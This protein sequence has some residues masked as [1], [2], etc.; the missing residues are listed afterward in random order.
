MIATARNG[1]HGT[2]G[3]GKTVTYVPVNQTEAATTIL[4]AASIGNKHKVLGA[5]LTLSALGTIKFTDGVGD[6]MG[7]LDIAA[8][9]GFLPP[10]SAIP[11]LETAATNRALNLVTT[12]AA[13]R[14]VVVLLTE[15]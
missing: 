7:P 10:T 2:L 3:T 9:S 5:I 4:A 11:Y 14:G 12:G 13:A 1:I 8:N 15:P 6:V